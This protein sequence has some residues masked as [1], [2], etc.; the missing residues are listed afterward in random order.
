MKV[1]LSAEVEGALAA[2]RPVVALES[3]VLAQGLPEAE[4]PA[5]WRRCEAAVRAAGAVPATTAVIEGTLR[6]G[7]TE[8]DVL[9]LVERRRGAAKAAR[10]D[11]GVLAARGAD[12]GTTVSALLAIARLAGIRVAATGGIGGVHR[13]FS[14]VQDESADLRAL[15][16]LPVAL[17]CAGAKAILDLPATL[18]RLETLSVPVLGYRTHVFPAF[19]TMPA[20]PAG[21]TLE[22]RVDSPE[23]AAR[24]LSWHLSLG[25][26]GALVAVPPPERPGLGAVQVEAAIAGALELLRERG[27]SGKAV[28]PFLLAEVD[29]RTGGAALAANLGLLERNARTAGEVAAAWPCG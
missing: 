14:E 3:S 7:L 22:A 18:E 29:R 11:L 1:R 15:A 20:E 16:E 13:R 25:G 26:G 23:E 2:G 19:Y 9:R 8:E 24:A 12:G 6:A 5:A 10:R 28:T 4:G 21:L 27:V 17:F